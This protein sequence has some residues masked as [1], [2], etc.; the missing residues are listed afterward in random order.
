MLSHDCL[1]S[2]LVTGCLDVLLKLSSGERD[3]IRVV[4]EVIHELRDPGDSEAE[5]EMVILS[6]CTQLI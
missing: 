6:L 5:D 3:L 4:V 2:S 1:P